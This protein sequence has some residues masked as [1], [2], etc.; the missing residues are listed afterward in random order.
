MKMAA[1][2]QFGAIITEA[3]GHEQQ[4]CLFAFRTS[5]TQ[6]I[7][8][9]V[10]KAAAINTHHFNMFNTEMSRISCTQPSVSRSLSPIPLNRPP[11]PP[12]PSAL[13]RDVCSAAD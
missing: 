8:T 3:Q 2:A 1:D 4:V 13:V 9:N 10:C 5:H 7:L 11:S 12:P 6:C